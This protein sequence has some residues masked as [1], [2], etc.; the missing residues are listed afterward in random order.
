M[1]DEPKPDEPQKPEEQPV[2]WQ[3][4]IDAIAPK[5]AEIID[6]LLAGARANA[7]SA[8]KVELWVVLLAAAV[9]LA[10]AATAILAAARGSFD[11]AERLLIPLISFAGGFGIGARISRQTPRV[12]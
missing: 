9:V 4:L 5:A 3:P 8:M 1:A 7:E 2:N 12:N 10:V 6:K 11:T